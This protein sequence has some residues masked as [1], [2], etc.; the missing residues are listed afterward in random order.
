MP[1]DAVHT[2]AEH[3]VRVRPHQRVVTTAAHI[4]EAQAPGGRG[5][6]HLKAVW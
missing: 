2:E 1:A 3:G 4:E 5:C 6:Q